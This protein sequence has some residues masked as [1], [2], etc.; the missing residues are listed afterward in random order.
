MLDSLQYLRAIASIMVVCFHVHVQLERMDYHGWWPASL[1][2]GVDL[3]FIISGFLMLVTTTNRTGY[4]LTFYQKRLVRI[5]PLYW[6][7]TSLFVFL[8][9]FV[10]S[11]VQSGRPEL[12][13][14]IASYLFLPAQHPVFPTIEP[15]VIPG[16]T[17]NY[18]MFFYLVWGLVLLLPDRMRVATI[19]ALFAALVLLGAALPSRNV[20]LTFYTSTIIIE[21]I[22]GVMVG[23]WYL[24]GRALPVAAGWALIGV[25]FAV[26]LGINEVALQTRFLLWGI[27]AAM[28]VVGALALEKAGAVRK[29]PFF[30]M[31]GDASYS[32][33]IVHGIALSAAGQIW[34]KVVPADLPGGI[35]VFTVGAI[36]A[37]VAAGVVVHF[38]I[39]RPLLRLMSRRPPAQ[40]AANLP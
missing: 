1:A 31:L 34:R 20:M 33:Y 35:A 2:S 23:I 3:F 37:A 39:E 40:V 36:I 24:Q 25:G 29:Y 6:I 15:V 21:F 28:I 10:P 11:A 32:I 7:I 27:P 18:E 8:M 22:F 38:T 19:I 14:I 26:M 13:H 17:L 16:W 9:L 5:V 12:W 4:T 30:V